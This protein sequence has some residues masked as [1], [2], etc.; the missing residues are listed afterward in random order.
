MSLQIDIVS[1]VVC[2]WCFI[3][4]RHLDQALAVYQQR[5]PDS[6][7]PGVRWHPFQLNPRLPASGIPRAEYTATKFG[8]PERA[9]EVYARVAAAGAKAGI[10]FAFDRIEVQPNTIDAHRLLHRAAELGI[11]HA[12]AE[13]LFSGYFLEGRNL[14]DR[15]T[16]GELAQRAG[17]SAGEAKRY[18]DSDEDRTLITQQDEHARRMGVEGVPF[19]IFNQRLAVS[20]AQPAEIL[21]DAM[22]RAEASTETAAAQ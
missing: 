3:G 11:Q 22:E 16:L 15:D 4:K 19:F 12:M 20:G 1:D 14:T 9:K 10:G 5:Y 2:P 18:L 6:P 13:S 7:V 21:L 17:M 8:G